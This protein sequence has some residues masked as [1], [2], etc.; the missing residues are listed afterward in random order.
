VEH[1]NVQNFFTGMD[2]SLHHE[3]PGTWLAVTSLSFDISVLE[4]LWAL[5]RGFKVVLYTGGAKSLVSSEASDMEPVGP[6]SFSLFFFSSDDGSTGGGAYDLLMDAA[7]FADT[8]GFEAV[9]TPERHFHAFGGPFPNPSVTSA[10]VAAITKNVAIRAGS[11]VLPLHSPIRVAEEW[12]VVDNLSHGRAGISFAAGWQPDDFVLRPE[13]FSDAKGV[14]VRDIETVRKLWR[15]ESVA[16]PG[17]DG[18]P[19]DVTVLPRPVQR[20]LPVWI[21]SAGNIE[22]FRLA[23]EMRTNILTHLLGQSFSEVAERIAAYRAAWDEAGHPG[24]GQVTLMLHTF[25]GESDYQV[26]E[27]VREPMIEYLRSS[28]G[29]IKQFAWSFPAFKNR[30]APGADTQSLFE[31]LSDTEMR[32]LLEHSFERYYETSGLF[33]TPARCAEIIKN[34]RTIGVDE[35]ACLVDFGVARA[36]VIEG[37]KLLDGVRASAQGENTVARASVGDLVKQHKVTHLQC[38][39]SMATVLMGDASAREALSTLDCMI[40]GGEAFPTPLANDLAAT[41]SGQVINMYGPTETTIW[42]TTHEVAPGESSIPI[43]RPIANTSIYILDAA[44]N[45][46]PVG[47]VGEL[48]I[49]GAG[50]VR[51]YLG[52]PELT[53]ERFIP[54]PFAQTPGERIYRTGDLARYR[55][56]GTIEFL[57]RIDNQVKLRGYRIEL[58][59]IE[60]AIGVFE[61][62]REAVVIA[63]EDEPGDQRLAAYYV[64]D[65]GASVDRSELREALSG[66]LPAFMV[67]SAFV[68]MEKLP[69]TPN[70]K[71]DRKALP[72]PDAIEP[73]T[74][75]RPIAQASGEVEERI[76]GI[77]GQ[78]LNTN[79]VDRKTTF[80]DLGG[81]S[82]LLVQVHRRL[83]DAQGPGVTLTDLFRFPTVESLAVHL[84][85]GSASGGSPRP[86]RV[87]ARRAALSRR[88]DSAVGVNRE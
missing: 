35:V 56:D 14:M 87:D 1:R 50:V 58:G 85:G 51:G 78:V 8:H 82:L 16:F 63:R 19:V 66:K 15:G 6:L 42:S 39:P 24:R 37:L 31:S 67:P 21:T 23:G 30:P 26:R 18:A 20:E 34:V 46:V 54:N 27:L 43:G 28:V 22:T 11:C 64:V 7:R 57:G 17:F 75:A 55:E 52:R 83:L 81:N 12:S 9:W 45:P 86:G 76:A 2:E 73:S 84:E 36:K 59:E 65:P 60:T 41:V 88:R 80:F 49:G 13:N 44:G 32:E 4:V 38:T 69:L 25:V 33:G 61:G 47:S 77:W 68:E 10:A 72:R 3:S 40:V 62:V 79:S 48:F 74:S 53:A 70:A 71:V 29:L 5:T